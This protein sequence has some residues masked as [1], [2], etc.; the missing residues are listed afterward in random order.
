[1]LILPYLLTY[2]LITL[3]F[4]MGQSFPDLILILVVAYAMLGP[5]I[6]A[7]GF[8]FINGLLLDLANPV[9]LGLNSLLF[10]ITAFLA[11][12]LNKIFFQ[13]IVYQYLLLI[14]LFTIISLLRADPLLKAILTILVMIPTIYLLSWKLTE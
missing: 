10:T 4:N 5:P 6:P 11:L 13:R 14:L 3:S 8:G 1:M 12:R 2:L 9:G 7:L